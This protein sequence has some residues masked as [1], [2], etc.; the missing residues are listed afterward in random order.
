M[1]VLVMKEYAERKIVMETR[2]VYILDRNTGRKALDIFFGYLCVQE[3]GRWEG[4]LILLSIRE[5]VSRLQI[6]Q[7]D[8]NCVFHFKALVYGD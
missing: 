1:V 2:D 4:T 5:H 7:Y 3:E 6:E 8:V